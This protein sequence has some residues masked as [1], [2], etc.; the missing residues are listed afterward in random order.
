MVSDRELLFRWRAKDPDA[1]QEL[2]D[3]HN[4]AVLTFLMRLVYETQDVEELVHDTFM[5]CLSAVT[6]FQGEDA[7]FR[8]YLLGIAYNKFREYLRRRGRGSRLIDPHVNSETV[9]E[10]TAEDLE[11]SDPSAFV[12]QN[13][14]RKLLLKA[15]RRIPIDYQLPLHLSFWEDLTNPQIGRILGVPVGTVASRL[16]L[17]K[18][19]LLAK[20]SEFAA[21]AALVESTRNTL[22]KWHEDI[23]ARA[24]SLMETALKPKD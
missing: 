6:P 10:V 22:M 21:D 2:F 12:E 1:G 8:P 16:R 14:E 20:L 23:S 9:A 5:T 7:V 24:K 13:E 3:R 4:H 15:L 19:R 18:E 17:G 11:I